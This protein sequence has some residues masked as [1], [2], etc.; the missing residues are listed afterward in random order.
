MII[1][2]FDEYT[3][4]FI[5]LT[6][7]EEQVRRKR[8]EAIQNEKQALVREQALRRINR[9]LDS[10]ACTP[11]HAVGAAY[12]A[13]HAIGSRQ[14]GLT[15]LDNEVLA[16]LGELANDDLDDLRSGSPGFVK[17]VEQWRKASA[18]YEG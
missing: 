7:S 16:H 8:E 18:R 9:M 14:I 13:G 5:E 17:A 11:E 3:G 6:V 2:H 10:G 1:H 15:E 12:N 4:R